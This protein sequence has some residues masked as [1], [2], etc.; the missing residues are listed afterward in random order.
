VCVRICHVQRLRRMS[1]VISLAFI[2]LSSLS[3]LVIA[4][5][6]PIR[7]SQLFK[8]LYS[9][10]KIVRTTP[11]ISATTQSLDAAGTHEYRDHDFNDVLHLARA[12]RRHVELGS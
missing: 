3:S 6:Y 8:S 12:V 5:C 7:I 10:S 11:G 9:P 2:V 1:H 4:Y